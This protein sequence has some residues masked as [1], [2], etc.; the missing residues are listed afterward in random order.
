MTDRAS[1]AGI[2]FACLIVAGCASTPTAL[3]PE[4]VPVPRPGL[5]QIP[6]QVAQGGLLLGTVPA[7]SLVV[8]VNPDGA[9]ASPLRVSAKGRFVMGVARDATGSLRLRVTPAGESP[10]EYVVVIQARTF[11][12][13]IIEGVPQDTVTPPPEIEA[14]IEREQ[15]RVAAAR[16]RDDDRDDF[17]VRF[18]WPVLGRISGEFGSTR[19]YNG[20]PGAPHSGMDVAATEG[21]PVHAPAAGIVSFADPDLYLTGGTLVIDHGHGLSSTFLHLSRIDVRVGERVQQDQIIGA[22]GKTGRATGPHLHWG[23]NWFEVR[24]DPHLLV[25]PAENPQT[26]P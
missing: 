12:Q 7:G 8:P 20:T 17:D 2:L 4:P 3:E 24:V 5:V 26:P 23:M 9:D 11:P 19:V 13:E 10:R 22:V 16:V 14:R 21:T 6:T 15:A 1:W 25:D 18:H